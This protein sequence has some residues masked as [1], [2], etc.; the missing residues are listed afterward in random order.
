MLSHW[1]IGFYTCFVALVFYFIS[2]SNHQ[3]RAQT[4]PFGCIHCSP[5]HQGLKEVKRHEPS[6]KN[7]PKR[8]QSRPTRPE[9]ARAKVARAVQEHCSSQKL[10]ITFLK[11]ARQVEQSAFKLPEL[12]I[13]SSIQ[14]RST[15]HQLN[16]SSKMARVEQSQISHSVQFLK[17]LI[18]AQLVEGDS[19][20]SSDTGGN[21]FSIFLKYHS[22]SNYICCF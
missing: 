7:K 2:N 10:S 21:S 15:G 17:C 18:M 4:S 22:R 16:W 20:E 5:K 11:F 6:H 14:F 1:F 9:W 13:I 19:L 12:L 8:S 3:H